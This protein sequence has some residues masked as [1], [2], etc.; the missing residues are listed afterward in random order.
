MRNNSGV[1]EASAL[2]PKVCP[3]CNSRYDGGVAFCS[4]DG[5]PLVVDPGAAHA[6]LVGTVLAD[7]YRIVRLLGEGGM[8]QVY[9]AQHLNINK[10]FAI[11]LLRPEIVSNQEAVAR[12][13]QEAWSASSIGDENIVEIDD[14]A[15]LPNGSVYLAMEY[16]QGR[17]LSERMR[18]APPVALDEALD[19]LMQVCRGLAAAHAKGIVHRD[20]KP[21]NVFLAEKNGRTVAKILDFGIAK[22]SGAEGAQSLT[23]TG[24]IFGTPHYMSPEQALGRALDHRTD[25]YSV[26]VIMYELFTGRVPFEAE[27]FMGILTKHITVQPTPP[28][29]LSPEREILVEVEAVILRAMAKEVADRYQTMNDLLGELLVLADRHAPGL[30]LVPAGSRSAQVSAQVS[31]QMA[32]ALP[33]TAQA[34]TP[35]AG[36][37]PAKSSRVG[38]VIAGVIA[39]L[40][41]A[42]AVAL[43]SHEAPTVAAVPK[44]EKEKEKSTP[45]VAHPVGKTD[46]SA[47][48]DVEIRVDSEP[49]RAEILR[50]DV[51][52]GDTPANLVLVGGKTETI[53]LRKA[54]Y[55]TESVTLRANGEARKIVRLAHVASSRP[56]EPQVAVPPPRPVVST[57]A[58]AKQPAVKHPV[59]HGE[60][61]KKGSEIINPY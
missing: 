32:A 54:G 9:E 49:A 34:A 33:T 8:G 29:V 38:V 20:M 6:D 11:K 30:L 10:R 42:T 15:T 24:T 23:R 56:K 14:F 4:R 46:T 5:T 59:E 51:R 39:V 27:S 61:P 2:T 40:G 60:D 35:T 7:R 58:T 26:G 19:V 50:G 52:F 43:R 44:Q 31:K 1:V 48:K 13:R 18:A 45:A 22:V 17:A 55:V 36:M 16:L 41:L 53:V 37:A 25:I 47:A 21:E 12:F 57:P 3:A 28:R